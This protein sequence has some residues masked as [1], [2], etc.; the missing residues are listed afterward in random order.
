MT[1]PKVATRRLFRI[2]NGGT[3]TADPDNWDGGVSWATPADL[4]ISN[5]AYV[6][7]TKRNL[8][9]V[10]LLR[11][12]GSV[13][14]GSLIIST[15]APIGYVAETLGETAFNQGCRGL[16][17]TTEL[18]VR[19]HRYQYFALARI[20]ASHGL[21]STFME[22]SSGDL[23]AFEV[24]A[25]PLVLQRAI[26]DF[27]DAETTRIDAIIAKK[28]RLTHLVQVRSLSD[29]I[30][31]SCGRNLGHRL[32]P[33][34]HDWLGYIPSHWPIERL[35]YIARLESG[36][37]PSRSNEALW[38]DC[39]IPW[40]T[41]NDVGYLEAHEYVE[42]TTNLISEQGL[43]VS[44]A[45]VLPA[46]TVALSRDATIGRCGILAT[47]M[48]TSQH[49]VNW[50]CSP[51]L[52]PRFLW[53]LFRWAMQTHFDTLTAGAT[54]KTIGMPD[55]KRMVVPVPSIDEQDRIV[56]EANAVRSRAI[57][58]LY[59]LDQQIKLLQEHRQALIT[60]AVTGEM[61]VPG[62]SG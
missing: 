52:R 55:I 6:G 42:E 37:T 21:G 39:K 5:G 60:A 41:L 16:M 12:S 59:G 57:R 45:R 8:S 2:V 3:P 54:L 11:G 9:R 28:S 40:I 17:P 25:P 35:K 32:Q 1:W 34:G 15:R 33:S 43:A 46:G 56:A 61:E 53:L 47:P 7:E 14:A 22:L 4:A 19:F 49:F 29:Q 51:R 20:L 30:D 48:A 44:S 13:P 31:I 50:I 36:H 26:A 23:A 10:G 18:D 24:S 62:V 58:I 27:L 38:V